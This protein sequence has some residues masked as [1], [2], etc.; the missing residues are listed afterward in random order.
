MTEKAEGMNRP[1]GF[2][3]CGDVQGIGLR[4]TVK[5]WADALG[6]H[7][8]IRNQGDRVQVQVCGD[9]AAVAQWQARVQAHWPALAWQRET[10][11]TADP[12]PAGFH[13]LPG[14]ERPAEGLYRLPADRG[15]CATCLHEFLDP[16][17]RRFHYPFISCN[18][19]GPRFS[20]LQRLPF[21]REATR[22]RDW[23][24]CTDCEAEFRDPANRRFHSELISCHRCGP[25]LWQPGT[26][27]AG[28]ADSSAT[29]VA[30]AVACLNAG[31]VLAL[32]S[33]CGMQLLARADDEQA[34]QRVRQYKQRP[35]KPLA[36][37]VAS[38]AVAHRLAVVSDR[39]ADWL[40]S[41]ARPI[42]LLP[43]RETTGLLAPS[44]APDM[45]DLGLLL[46]VT[47][48]Q[49]WLARALDVPL[50]CTSANRSDEP[51]L[52]RNED[53]LRADPPLCDQA[54]LHDL[55]AS[56]PQDD[57]VL[58]EQQGRTTLLR[59]ARG[60]S[61]A[62]FTV[63]VQESRLALGGDLKNTF[64]LSRG[65]QALLSPHLG[66]LDSLATVQRRDWLLQQ[67]AALHQWQ[68]RQIRVDAHPGYV[69]HR[70]GA[71][72]APG[73][74]VVTVQHHLAHLWTNRVSTAL[75]AR[76]L[77]LVWD[78]N[79]FGS[80][81]T[82]WGS[83]A[84]VVDGERVQRLATLAP[85]AL[86]GGEQALRQPWRV[87]V[88]LAHEARIGREDTVAVLASATV[89]A[90]RI[91]SLW[92]LLDARLNCPRSHAAGRL[93]DAL[94]YR[95]LGISHN[96]FEGFA[97]LQLQQSAQ[98]WQGSTP[99]A[100]HIETSEQNGLLIGHWQS[101]WRNLFFHTDTDPAA[102]AWAFHQGLV[103]WALTLA[104]HSDTTHLSLSGGCFQNRLLQSLLLERAGTAGIPV[105][106]PDQIPLN[107]GGLALGQLCPPA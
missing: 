24:R 29:L 105:Q 14:A 47:A 66:D 41:P 15:I 27:P 64:A 74:P 106:W 21:A 82:L 102:W 69:S 19:C 68:P 83:E 5:V 80:D 16:A 59:R 46:P 77:A 26:V 86:P 103:N 62:P 22:Y 48:L 13:I 28:D 88:A 58:F 94:A 54:L 61:H 49:A 53:L 55:D 51:I 32:K 44:V 36:L 91:H 63:P 60:F 96:R 84:F 67:Y 33:F 42:V 104:Q 6:L 97:A 95:L 78:G 100:F 85:F 8:W 43:R 89:P 101:A 25:R 10:W 90:Q 3:L 52:F 81:G 45:P 30:Q 37:L 35:H 17:N 4:P 38:L 72:L 87:A 56:F 34:V 65:G 107:D 2:V 99:P 73:M 71:G 39:A 7:G 1:T 57:S 20:V 12:L 93:F 98:H 75:P 79:G 76:H 23:P 70:Q 40:E 92:Q 18:G 9:A 50:I 11:D 31:G